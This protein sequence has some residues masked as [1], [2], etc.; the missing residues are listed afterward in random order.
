MHIS[1]LIMTTAIV[2]VMAVPAQQTQASDFVKGAAVGAILGVLGTK[3]V[4]AGQ[5]RPSPTHAPTRQ[6]RLSGM[7]AAQREQNRNVQNALNH[8]NYPVGNADGVLGPRSRDQ[9]AQYERDMGLTT[10]GRLDDYERNFLIGSY[11]RAQQAQ[12][13]GGPDAAILAQRGTR[14]LLQHYNQERLG[15]ANGGN[16]GNGYP[17]NAGGGYPNNANTFNQNPAGNGFNQG[18]AAG[19]QSTQEA[20]VAQPALPTFMPTA[21]ARSMEQHCQSTSLLTVANGSAMNASNIT[22]PNQA[23]NEQFCLAK[24]F[25]TRQ[26]E[27]QA[28]TIGGVTPDQI[29]AQCRGVA[30][31]LKPTLDT[32][33]TA[34]VDQVVASATQTITSQGSSPAAL[35]QTSQICLSSGY[36]ADDPE[37]SAASAILLVAA[38]QTPYGEIIGH[39]LR[40][41]F[42]FAANRER[43]NEW[44]T[45]ALDAMATGTPP[46]I[47]PNQASG[48]NAVIRT[49]IG[50]GGMQAGM[51][52]APIAQRTL[53]V[54]PLR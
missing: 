17:N 43:A 47:L 20:S 15:F 38:G 13:G 30:D 44:Y 32:V 46:T 51:S 11:A 33:P 41:G 25:T 26:G 52:P 37:I 7:S 21:R 5:R 29:L 40:E 18:N 39:Q 31:L 54:Q 8:F 2:A 27:A 50:Q 3:A 19:F 49:A 34:S 35:A 12:Y 22:D 24:E 36:A 6:P 45:M 9:I 1:K 16:T 48:R 53:V 14:G 10:D 4:E 28:A 23:L 42:G